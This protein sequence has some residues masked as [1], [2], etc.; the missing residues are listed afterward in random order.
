MTKKLEIEEAIQE[1]YREIPVCADAGLEHAVKATLD[2]GWTISDL[3]QIVKNW[4]HE[5]DTNI[6]YVDINYALYDH[7]FI[8]VR[9]TLKT[10][11]YVDIENDLDFAITS[12]IFGTITYDYTKSS[13]NKLQKIVDNC[14]KA[15]REVIWFDA[16]TS[17]FFK[18]IG[19]KYTMYVVK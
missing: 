7:I 15:Q 6:E 18:R 8:N 19:I 3:I 11:C 9:N 1:F 10:T 12:N 4:A 17:F 13:F 14:T 5:T 2:L 16:F